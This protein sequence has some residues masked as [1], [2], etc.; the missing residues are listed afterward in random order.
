[1]KALVLLQSTSTRQA[2]AR[3]VADMLKRF[4]Y[5]VHVTTISNSGAGLSDLLGAWDPITKLTANGFAFACLSRPQNATF[6]W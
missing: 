6:T 5:E 3:Q 1:M 2:N 4:G